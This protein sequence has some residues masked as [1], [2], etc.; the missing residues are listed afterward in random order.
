MSKSLQLHGL[1]TTRLL[2]SWDS[3]GNNTGAGCRSLL[4]G[5][6]LT[7]GL[8]LVLI[9]PVLAG[10]FLTI[11][12]TWEAHINSQLSIYLN[13]ENSSVASQQSVFCKK[14]HTYIL[15]EKEQ[16]SKTNFESFGFFLPK[17]PPK[18]PLSLPFLP[19]E[20][21]QCF[22]TLFGLQIS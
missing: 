13:M 21:Q 15:S 7:Q 17:S 14:R 12:A 22:I 18:L 2:C 20:L 6:F 19:S 11:S 1:Q 9:S 3:P 5:I 10:G 8:N 4:Q 16:V